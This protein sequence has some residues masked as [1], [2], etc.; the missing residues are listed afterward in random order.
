MSLGLQ[1]RI[2]RRAEGLGVGD[3][4]VGDRMNVGVQVDYAATPV[5]RRAAPVLFG[6]RRPLAFIASAEVTVEEGADAGGDELGDLLLGEDGVEVGP[7][8]DRDQTCE[9][10]G[11]SIGVVDA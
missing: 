9:V 6:E 8:R 4:V 7:I 1:E 11:R 10:N 2:C 3:A 5:W